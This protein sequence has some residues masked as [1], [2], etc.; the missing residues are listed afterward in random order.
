MVMSC[1]S[2]A[3]CFNP[4]TRVGCDYSLIDGCVISASFNPRTRVGCDKPIKLL[5]LLMNR[6][7]PRTRVGCDISYHPRRTR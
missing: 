2:I 1:D 6:F 3:V 7:N 4:R 5:K